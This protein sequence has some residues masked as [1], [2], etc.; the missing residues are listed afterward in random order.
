MIHRNYCD[1]NFEKF[2]I[3]FHQ[4]SHHPF[5]PS[6]ALTMLGNFM[7]V[8]NLPNLQQLEKLKLMDP[9]FAMQSLRNMTTPP[10]SGFNMPPSGDSLTAPTNQPHNLSQQKGF[11]FTTPNPPNTKEGNCHFDHFSFHLKYSPSIS[12]R[13]VRVVNNERKMTKITIFNVI[14]C[15]ISIPFFLRIR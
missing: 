4:Y 10:N 12:L 3:F 6:H 14:K 15:P 2:R 5:A 13:S 11:S 8:S 1:I 7:G 9:E